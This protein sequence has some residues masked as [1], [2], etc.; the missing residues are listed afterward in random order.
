MKPATEPL[1]G[2]IRERA[3]HL[4]E[5]SGRPLGRDQEFWERA[6]ALIALEDHPPTEVRVRSTRSKAVRSPS[7]VRRSR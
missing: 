4:W 1:E 6:H 7:S 2:R 3:Y 5:A